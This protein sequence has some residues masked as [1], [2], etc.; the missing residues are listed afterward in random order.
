MIEVSPT[1]HFYFTRFAFSMTS[2]KVNR[3][4]V[5]G[6]VNEKHAREIAPK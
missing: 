2:R 4:L 5:E 1:T 6:K 3:K